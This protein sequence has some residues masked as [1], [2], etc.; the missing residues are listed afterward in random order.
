MEHHITIRPHHFLCLPGYKGYG[1][2]KEH[3]NSWDR[4]SQSL[5]QYPNM[6]L[7]IVKGRDTLCEKC[8][9]NG[10]SGVN[11]NENFLKKLDEKVKKL[12]GLDEKKIYRYDEIL[13]KLKDLLD[14]KK[15]AE[16]CGDCGWREY[17]LCK[18]TFKKVAKT[19]L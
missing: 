5:A 7:K 12:L 14:P 11:C 19:V 17:G 1:Y 10:E 6:K 16:L 4:L 9:N 8:P 15:H 3:A 18:D 2:S 13:D